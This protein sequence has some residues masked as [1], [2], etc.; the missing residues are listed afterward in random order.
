MFTREEYLNKLGPLLSQ[1][2][3]IL[4]EIGKHDPTE[5]QLE[6][7]RKNMDDKCELLKRYSEAQ[8]INCDKEN[9]NDARRIL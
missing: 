3:I 6:R 8:L 9:G 4:K 7:L 2:K 1:Q 5:D